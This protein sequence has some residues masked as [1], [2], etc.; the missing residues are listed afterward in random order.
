VERV[1]RVVGEGMMGVELLLDKCDG[2]DDCPSFMSL[3]M[4]LYGSE[5][6]EC[7]S[8]SVAPTGGR[9]VLTTTFRLMMIVSVPKSFPFQSSTPPHL[10]HANHLFE[11]F[12]TVATQ[13]PFPFYG[14]IFSIGFSFRLSPGYSTDKDYGS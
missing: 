12:E 4:E 14:T 5:R 13:A 11:G 3:M 9:I 2:F 8:Q 1:R 6:P 10:F 7:V